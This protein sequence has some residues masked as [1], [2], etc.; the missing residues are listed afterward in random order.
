MEAVSGGNS[1]IEPGDIIDSIVRNSKKL[2]KCGAAV[3]GGISNY[4]IIWKSN[5][6]Y[7]KYGDM[8]RTYSERTVNGAIKFWEKALNKL[9]ITY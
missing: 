5:Y 7:D 1:S 9:H 8:Y 2:G 3:V 4:W 6:D